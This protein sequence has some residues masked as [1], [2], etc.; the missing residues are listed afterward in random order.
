MHHPKYNDQAPIVEE[1]PTSY[2]LY[3]SEVSEEAKPQRRPN[4]SP[5]KDY[6]TDKSNH[7]QEAPDEEYLSRS[8]ERAYFSN[9][10]SSDRA[11]VIGELISAVCPDRYI[12]FRLFYHLH[13]RVLEASEHKVREN[14]RHGAKQVDYLWFLIN[15]MK[16]KQIKR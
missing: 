12:S 4:Y 7:V 6:V 5:S 9:P 11:R 8:G 2:H 15:P 10:Y 3:S 16:E 13:R 14:H 1:A